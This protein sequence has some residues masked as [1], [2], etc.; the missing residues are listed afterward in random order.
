M[1]GAIQPASAA[2]QRGLAMI[3]AKIGLE[4]VK[5]KS[6]GPPQWRP[7]LARKDTTMFRKFAIAL[8]A[9]AALAAPVMAQNS[10][11]TAPATPATN[12]AAATP[13]VKADKAAKASAVT[14]H[15]KR[16]HVARLHTHFKHAAYGKAVTFAHHKGGKSGRAGNTAHAGASAASKQVSAKPVTKS[17]VN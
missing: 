2:V 17:G 6:S 13:V 16:H 7:K 12:S 1:N 14:Q 8:V 3:A 15:R 9:T 4:S 5:T 11:A 10:T